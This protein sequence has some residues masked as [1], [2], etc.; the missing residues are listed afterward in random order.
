PRRE[1]ARGARWTAPA[2]P[3]RNDGYRYIARHGQGYSRFEHVSH[4]IGLDLLQFVP[5]D[6]PVKISRLKIKNVSGRRRRLS[7]TAY[8]EWVLGPSRAT[9]APFVFTV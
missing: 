1:P 5:L 8:A 9:C 4:G 2:L 3:V 7:I 6:D